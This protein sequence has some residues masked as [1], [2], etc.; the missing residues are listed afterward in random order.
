M[1]DITVLAIVGSLRSASLNRELAEVIA[2]NPPQGVRIEIAD[3]IAD[4]PFY[5][6]D[7]DGADAPAP[8]AALRDRIRDADALLLLAPPNNGTLSAVLKNVI[9]WGSRPYGASALS[10]KRVALAGVGHRLDTTLADAERAVTIAG[11][12]VPEGLV[13]EFPISGLEGKSP[14]EHDEAVRRA[15]DLVARLVEPVR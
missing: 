9:D 13:V 8:A 14:R 12:E 4:V 3:G 10:G 7:I 6:E 11:G 5:N 15:G 1:S 2:E